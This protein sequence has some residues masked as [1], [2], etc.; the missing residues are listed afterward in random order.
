MILFNGP[1]R[2]IT[3]TTPGALSLRSMWSAYLLWLAQPG[4]RKYA[5]MLSS[6]GMLT[7]D[8]PLYLFLE[9]GVTL[10][11]ADNSA[12]TVVGDGVLKTRDDRDPFGGAVVNV[13]YEAPGIAIGYSSSGGSGPT[14]D[15]IAAAVAT[16]PDFKKLL[17]TA[18]FLALK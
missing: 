14:A 17:T 1:A 3:L 8:I 18:R 9:A 5:L 15:S 16:H 4:N 6:V 11:I 10:V 13:R 2:T 7:T 12:P